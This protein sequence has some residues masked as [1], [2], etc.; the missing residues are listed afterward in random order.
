M[1]PLPAISKSRVNGPKNKKKRIYHLIHQGQ[2]K[3]AQPIPASQTKRLRLPSINWRRGSIGRIISYWWLEFLSCVT[4]II[5]FFGLISILQSY[6]DQPLPDWPRGLTINTILSVLG[7]IFKGPILLIAAEGIG[8]LKWRWLTKRRPLSDLSTYDE[9]SRGPWGA[10]KMLWKTR[11]RHILGSFGALITVLGL[12]IDPFTQAVVSYYRCSIE[13]VTKSSSISR[14]NSFYVDSAQNGPANGQSLS[15][16]LRVAIDSGFSDS[17]T[18]L[19]NFTCSTEDCRFTQP[20]H[21]VGVCS[22]CSDVSHLLESNCGPGV[23]SPDDGTHP[24]NYSPICNYT[25]T[26]NID[27]ESY[28]TTAGFYGS[29]RGYLV[30]LPLLSINKQPFMLTQ[31]GNYEPNTTGPLDSYV[32]STIDIVS[33]PPVLGCRCWIYLCTRTYTATIDSGVLKE[34]LHSISSNRSTDWVAGTVRVDYLNS[35]LQSHLL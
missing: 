8:Q 31:N 34:T 3:G 1:T 30:N 14:L 10:T 33:F 28:N 20:Y 6:Q 23:F 13:D 17:T 25:L 5:T 9:A 12:G 22:R 7:V 26:S 24:K 32:S 15:T 29:T 11:G 27:S 2:T 19:P 16:S 35:E 21:S 4:I 18:V